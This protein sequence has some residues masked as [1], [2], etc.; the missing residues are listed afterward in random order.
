M[1]AQEAAS[2]VYEKISQYTASCICIYG[3]SKYGRVERP[4]YTKIIQRCAN[5]KGMVIMTKIPEK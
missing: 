2:R 5:Q 4:T 1:R 3:R